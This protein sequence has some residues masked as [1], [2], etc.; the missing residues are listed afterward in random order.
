MA[1]PNIPTFTPIN[2]TEKHMDLEIAAVFK[3]SVQFLD[4]YSPALAFGD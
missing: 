3:N 1:K 4:Q 2:S